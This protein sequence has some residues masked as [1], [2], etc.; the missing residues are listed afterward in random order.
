[1]RPVDAHDLALRHRIFESFASTGEPPSNLGDLHSLADQHVVALRDGRIW[2]AHSF[3]A[4]HEG[5]R[6]D[7]GGRT[8]WGNCAWDGLGIV[9]ALQL[10]DA[11]VTAQGLTVPH[12][13]AAFH[14]LVPASQWWDDIGFT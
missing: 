5:A 7:A 6:V 2:M 8:W 9:H 3:A 1:M 12:D 10:E 11:T 13:D 4:H 14:V